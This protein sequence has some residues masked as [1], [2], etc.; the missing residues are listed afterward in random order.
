MPC[1]DS[2]RYL[3]KDGYRRLREESDNRRLQYN[4]KTFRNH[5]KKIEELGVNI[6]TFDTEIDGEEVKTEKI[7][8]FTVLENGVK[9]INS[10]EELE[11]KNNTQTED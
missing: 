9:D 8:N 1:P 4:K 11:Q 2:R 10:K 5:V 7:K 6:L 3:H